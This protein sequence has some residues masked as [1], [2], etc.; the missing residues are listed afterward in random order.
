M[1]NKEPI[2]YAPIERNLDPLA[3]FGLFDQI[4]TDENRGAIKNHIFQHMRVLRQKFAREKTKNLRGQNL[5]L[6]DIALITASNLEKHIG[7]TEF[8]TGGTMGKADSEITTMAEEIVD[9]VY[10]FLPE[11]DPITGDFDAHSR[12]IY[13]TVIAKAL[14]AEVGQTPLAFL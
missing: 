12:R 3:V 7:A 8:H 5:T 6:S 14:I 2:T 10:Q 11:R 1:N 9:Y 4:L 13:A